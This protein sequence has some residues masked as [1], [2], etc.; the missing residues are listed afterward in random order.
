MDSGNWPLSPTQPSP[1]IQKPCFLVP[2]TLPP[3]QAC[4]SFRLHCAALAFSHA[5]PKHEAPIF[6]VLHC[7]WQLGRQ[8]PLLLEFGEGLLL[9]V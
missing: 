7:V 4:H 3:P 8:F 5:C 1:S 2:I 9:A 6:L